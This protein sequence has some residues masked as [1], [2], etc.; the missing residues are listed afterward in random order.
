MQHGTSQLDALKSVGRSEVLLCCR[1]VISNSGGPVRIY[2]LPGRENY[3]SVV[4]NGI[5]SQTLSRWSA[6]FTVTS[7][8]NYVLTFV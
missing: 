4:A 5:Q 1:G 6:S 7:R 3:S 8:Y 2:S